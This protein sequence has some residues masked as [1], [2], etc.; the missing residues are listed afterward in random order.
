LIW[1]LSLVGWLLYNPGSTR[2]IA[3][4]EINKEKGGSPPQ[5]HHLPWAQRRPNLNPLALGLPPL[6]TT[7]YAIWVVT[8]T[9]Q[10][11]DPNYTIIM[12][13]N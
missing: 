10:E 5:P 1:L 9:P 3:I 7:P 4:Q 12:D 2:V 6:T 13:Q 8:H 11:T